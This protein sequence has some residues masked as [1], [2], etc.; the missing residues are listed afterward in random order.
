MVN[1]KPIYGFALIVG[2]VGI[3]GLFVLSKRERETPQIFY[4]AGQ[5]EYDMQHIGI[6]NFA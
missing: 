5:P 2:A 6:S 3:G 4:K 1:L